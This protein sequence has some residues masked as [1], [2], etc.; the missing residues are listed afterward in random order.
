MPAEEFLIEA[1]K[2]LTDSG[3]GD[4]AMAPLV[5]R[6]RQL[7]SSLRAVQSEGGIKNGLIML[8]PAYHKAVE[9]YDVDVVLRFF[10]YLSMT[11]TNP[12][13]YNRGMADLA[14]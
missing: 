13:G 6:V 8:E 14:K 2:L 11:E 4:D 5:G 1:R 7:A 3:E 10:D 12:I 9:V